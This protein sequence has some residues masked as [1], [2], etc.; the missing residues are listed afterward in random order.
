MCPST[1]ARLGLST[2]LLTAA[3]SACYVVPIDPRTGQ[4]VAVGQQP[5]SI[6]VVQPGAVPNAAP[7]FSSLQARLYPVNEQAQSAGLVTA[8]I[9]DQHAGRGS[10]S[11]A[12][13]GQTMQGDA[14]RVDAAYVGFGRIYNQVLGGSDTRSYGGRRGI[15]NAY[16]AN[17][18][19]AQCEYLITG[20]ALGTGACLFSDGAKYQMHF[21]Q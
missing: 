14:T 9:V 18:V 10:I 20:A 7:A 4:P 19:S 13:R 21:S 11:L 6:T 8:A 17:G 1:T 15:A 16:G 3:L 5:T 12:Y 2:L